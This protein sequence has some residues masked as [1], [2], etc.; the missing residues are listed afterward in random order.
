M[1][2][3]FLQYAY[4]ISHSPWPPEPDTNMRTAPE[5]ARLN[6]YFAKRGY[7][8]VNMGRMINEPFYG[9][10][11]RGESDCVA[12]MVFTAERFYNQRSAL[13][14]SVIRPLQLA[15][16]EWP[17]YYLWARRFWRNPQE[18]VDTLLERIEKEQRHTTTTDTV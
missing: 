9:L 16:R 2:K 13:S 6:P 1:L 10:A 12:G 8:L 11:P 15:S 18:A 7:T 5:M 17:V 14:R 4:T 3:A